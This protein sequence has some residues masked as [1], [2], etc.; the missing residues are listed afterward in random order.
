MA[1]M[2][3]LADSQAE[4]RVKLL[5][6]G[7]RAN[8]Q[9]GGA[10][11]GPR[12]REMVR[13]AGE[14]R[15]SGQKN[16]EIG[17]TAQ[18]SVAAEYKREIISVVVVFAEGSRGVS[19]TEC[20]EPCGDDG[21]RTR[22]AD[23]VPEPQEIRCNTHSCEP[24][25]G[26]CIGDVVFVIDS[27]GRIG[28]YNWTISLQFVIDVMKG[29]KISSK[30]THVG[31]VIYSTTVAACIGLKEYDSVV[32]IEP[33]VFNLEYMA[34]MTN[35]ADAI[36]EMHQILN[37]EAIGLDINDD[38]INGIASNPD[39]VFHAA[40]YGVVQDL[41][42]KIAGKICKI[43]NTVDSSDC[44]NFGNCIADDCGG[45][46]IREGTKVCWV[47][48]G[49]TGKEKPSSRQSVPC[50]EPCVKI[51]DKLCGDCGDFG[52]CKE[53][54]VE[55]VMTGTKECWMVDN[56][57]DEEVPSTR[58]TEPCVLPC[59]IPC[60][61]TPGTVDC[62]RCEYTKGQIWLE[63][64]YNCHLYYI[65]EPLGNGVYRVHHGTCGDLFWNQP[66]HTCVPVMPLDA[67]C[68]IGPVSPYIPEPTVKAWPRV[69]FANLKHIRSTTCQE[70]LNS[71]ALLSIERELTDGLNFDRNCGVRVTQS[72][73]VP[74]P[75]EPFPGDTSKFWISGNAQT[76]S[77]CIE[78]MEF[79]NMGDLCDCIPVGPLIPQCH[80]DLLLHFPYE[81]HYNDVTCHQAIA[82]QYGTGVSIQHDPVRNGNVA[83]F[84]GNTHFEVAFLRTWFAN[85]KVDKFSVS[86]WFKRDGQQ[87]SPQG[88]VHNGDCID[89]AGFLI[90][91]SKGMVMANITTE[92]G[93]AHSEVSDASAGDWYHVAWVY[94]GQCLKVYVDCVLQQTITMSGYLKNNDV[95]MYI[96][97][98][99]GEYFFTG[100]LDENKQ[101]IDGCPSC[102]IVVDDTVGSMRPYITQ[103]T[104]RNNNSDL[105][106]YGDRRLTSDPV[107]FIGRRQ[108]LQYISSAQNKPGVY[109]A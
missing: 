60:T 18:R 46:G 44:G 79:V 74:C 27:S 31:V 11:C 73:K 94:D 70:R 104:R 30:G 47:I 100:C 13:S 75:Y 102:R 66:Y 51:C 34:G 91:H 77:S 10:S 28:S 97:N 76:V 49:R 6:G 92:A 55:S 8:L 5:W 61:T 65:C 50:S 99:C 48:D 19:W 101:R 40:N 23:G 88:I 63:D 33:V 90:G 45:D 20:S 12:S 109:D 57:T 52:D 81:D 80:D 4:L 83:C 71:H 68:E 89:T 38:E 95:P 17:R 9:R 21:T 98:C 3:D 39:Y 29:L 84:A 16:G 106:Q 85:N 53:C 7:L 82:T 1:M 69:S 24:T 96:A 107:V 59:F 86:V 42:S 22:S 78:G 67:N 15:G 43:S 56:E 37:T 64:R 36:K 25:M 103:D 2:T 41:T 14:D 93:D 35:T 72:K 26:E 105:T 32:D 62:S 54:G 87:I 58:K 108:A